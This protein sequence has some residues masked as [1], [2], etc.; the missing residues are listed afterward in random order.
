MRMP[1]PVAAA[2]LFT[3]AGCSSNPA[4][5][6]VAPE[7]GSDRPASTSAPATATATQ[8]PG[9]TSSA[10]APP[11]PTLNQNATDK[12]GST[13]KW[14][15]G[16]SVAVGKP[17]EFEPSSSAV[18]TDPGKK[19]VL[20][21]FTVVNGSDKEYDPTDFQAS[22]QSGNTEAAH[23][24]DSAKGVSGAPSTQIPTGRET[25]LSLAFAVPDPADLTVL[26]APGLDYESVPFTS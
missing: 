4:T 12:L 5:G 20:I 16:V 21:T 2:V 24:Y 9:P 6:T 3:L 26:V 18:G 17:T 10:P 13:H 19:Y 11:V 8:G 15:N 1:V 22:V 14:Q 7:S 25:K 23:V